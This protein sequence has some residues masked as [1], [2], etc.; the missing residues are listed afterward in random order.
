MKSLRRALILLYQGIVLAVPCREIYASFW[1]DTVSFFGVA[2]EEALLLFAAAALFVGSLFIAVRRGR[3]KAVF[4]VLAW[5]AVFG[6][7]AALHAHH[8]LSFNTAVFPAAA[9]SFAVEGYYLVRMYF[10]PTSLIASFFLLDMPKEKLVSALSGALFLISGA[11][12]LTDLAGVSF[13]SYADGNTRVSGG[14]FSWFSLPETARF[15]LYTAK[16]PFSGANALGAILFASTPLYAAAA[17]TKRRARDAVLLGMLMLASVMVGTKVA[18]VGFFAAMAVILALFVWDLV[19]FR[20][21]G[22]WRGFIAPLA[23]L[24]VYIPLVLISPGFRMQMERAE[25]AQ[26][27]QRTAEITP[28]VLQAIESAA[29]RAEDETERVYTEEEIA[30]L[31]IYMR[32]KCYYHYVNEWFLELYPVRADMAFWT[33][34]VTRDNTLNRDNRAFKI[35]MVS[36]IIERNANGADAIFGIGYTSGVPYTE[37]D[38]VFQYDLYGVLGCLV[39]LAPFFVA[40]FCALRRFGAALIKK[41]PITPV[42]ATAVTLGALLFTAWFAGHVF[43]TLFS[44]YFAAIFAAIA[45]AREEV[46]E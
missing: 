29:S 5:C 28:E 11:V 13:A 37:R 14:F 17:C 4:A 10:A 31:E 39:L 8:V 9:P 32:N 27:D 26:T 12:I 43:D 38:F 34:I 24:A 1:G 7:Y 21:K 41:R 15:A 40:F 20:K 33:E 45:L 35:K 6:V 19:F 46:S 44:T 25:V 16:G 2:A 30:A 23:I 3:K 36:R 42:G 18:L 22:A